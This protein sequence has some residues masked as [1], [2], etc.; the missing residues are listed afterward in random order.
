[1]CVCVYII[2]GCSRFYKYTRAPPCPCETLGCISI[3]LCAGCCI[4]FQRQQRE[5]ERE[6]ERETSVGLTAPLSLSTL[7]TCII[8]RI[9]GTRVLD[10]E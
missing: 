3:T 5:R 7:F 9:R 6:R 2:S 4:I 1:M 10:D 8:N